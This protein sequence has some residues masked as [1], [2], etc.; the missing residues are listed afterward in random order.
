MKA[1]VLHAYNHLRIEGMTDPEPGPHEV[2]VAI[3]A[4]GICGS[5]V[6]GMDGS[7]GRRQPPIVMGHEASGVIAVVGAEV[8]DWRAGDRVTFDSTASCGECAY[9]QR[10]QINLCDCRRVFG[11]SCGDYRQHGAF[12]RYLSVPQ[13]ILYRV[14]DSLS[15]EHA[16]FVEPLS[17]AVHA[18][19]R[20]GASPDDTAVVIGAGVIGLLT[21][22][23]LRARGCQRVIAVDVD[24]SRLGI[25]RLCGAALVLN[26]AK[27]DALAKILDDTNGAGAALV[28]EAVGVEATVD[29]AV[30]CAAKGG[31]VVLIGNVSPRVGMALQAVVTRELSLL[32]SCASAGEYPACLELMASGAVDVAPLISAVAPLA[33]GPEWFRRLHDREAGL[34]KVILTPG[35][36]K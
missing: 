14:P 2:V 1:L 32:G 16:A 8:R 35:D 7:T 20:T 29:T 21:M 11:V 31:S 33:E 36:E 27:E 25:A 18:V 24:E 34:L 15:F 9:C 13:H 10:G 6:H 19:G 22:Q 23:V 12:A 26:S 17:V 4:C 28:F 30:R 5:D 3:R